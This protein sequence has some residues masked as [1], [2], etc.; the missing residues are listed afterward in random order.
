[1][2][3]SLFACLCCSVLLLTISC[4]KP[5]S[6]IPATAT[7]KQTVTGADSET[8]DRE[9]EARQRRSEMGDNGKSNR[10]VGEPR[11]EFGVVTDGL[12]ETPAETGAA[13]GAAVEKPKA[14]DEKS[15]EQLMIAGGGL[16]MIAPADWEKAE[17]ASS[18]IEIEFSV[19][20]EGEQASGRMTGMSAGGSVELNINRWYDQFSQ[21]DGSPSKDKAK[22]AE[23]MVGDL[24]VHTMDIS[25]TFLEGMGPV[26]PKTEREDYRMLAAIIELDGDQKYFLKFYGPQAMVEK[27]AEA[28]SGML[29]SLKPVD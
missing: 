28:F 21:P 6:S 10:S 27:N 4:A 22:V 9:R 18:M 3:R 23:L 16:R 20:G 7:G 11:R 12:P 8:I 14:I 26:A 19:P 1:M 25:G 24:K 17:P 15:N 5:D 13:S 29:Q 2:P